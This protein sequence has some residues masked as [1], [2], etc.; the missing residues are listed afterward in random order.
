[1]TTRAIDSSDAMASF[2][3][4]E[5][6]NARSKFTSG[7]SGTSLAIRSPSATGSDST[8]ATSRTASFGFNCE[9]VTI[10]D[11]FSRPYLAVTYSMT[12]PRRAWQKSMSMSGIEMRSGF[13]NR[14]KSR[15]YLSGSISVMRRAQETIDP[16]ALPR[17]GPTEMPFS[18]AYRM[19]SETIRKY[20]G[21]P[22]F[23]MTA[24][25]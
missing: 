12:S 8:R 17:P 6:R 20:D 24:I 13:R 9:K 18:R 22:I 19:K 7:P 14:S 16:A 21:K 10:C 1:M 15:S 5:S 11:T 4:G 3:P 25:S 2:R 23:S